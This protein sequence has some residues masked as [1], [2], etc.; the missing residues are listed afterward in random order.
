[1]SK[2]DKA[3]ALAHFDF[4]EAGRLLRCEECDAPIYAP[5]LKKKFDE[6][7]AD[8]GYE[9]VICIY[10]RLYGYYAGIQRIHQRVQCIVKRKRRRRKRHC[11]CK[12]CVE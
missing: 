9:C 5:F 7:V 2:R 8:G 6:I 12:C 11:C 10:Q 3:E 4:D 1:M